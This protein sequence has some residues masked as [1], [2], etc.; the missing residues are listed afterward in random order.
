MH[1]SPDT[2]ALIATA[3]YTTWISKGNGPKT[4]AELDEMMTFAV[5]HADMLIDRLAPEIQKVPMVFEFPE[6]AI[7]AIAEIEMVKC[8]PDKRGLDGYDAYERPLG[9]LVEEYQ[10]L[11]D[12]PKARAAFFTRMNKPL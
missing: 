1:I 12:D 10:S 9:R 5:D 8:H 2:R 3:I 4:K 6:G 7:D 11:K